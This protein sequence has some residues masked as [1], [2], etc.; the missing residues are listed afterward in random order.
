MVA[1]QGGPPDMAEDWRTH[2]PRAGVIGDVLAPETGV[3]T[4]ID[5][6]ALGRAVVALGGGRQVEGD[7]IDPSVGLSEVVKL[8]QRLGP[9]DFLCAVHARTGDEAERAARDGSRSTEAPRPARGRP[10]APRAPLPAEASSALADRRPPTAGP[11]PRLEA[12]DE[13]RASLACFLDTGFLVASP[14]VELTSCVKGERR[15]FGHGQG[16][17]SG[18]FRCAAPL[19]KS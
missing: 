3:V 19:K 17:Q 13:S 15:H 2:L 1:A 4:A 14:A 18:R 16:G 9:G 10:E 5:G 12:R 6:A 8:G 7:R 11:A